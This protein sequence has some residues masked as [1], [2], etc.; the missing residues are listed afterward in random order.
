MDLK[1]KMYAHMYS[2]CNE[3]VHLMATNDQKNQTFF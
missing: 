3:N 2:R 1:E